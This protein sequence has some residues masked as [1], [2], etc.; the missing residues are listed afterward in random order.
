MKGLDLSGLRTGTAQVWGSVRLVPL[1]R[2][3][4]VPGLRLH[5]RL[6]DADLT[7]VGSGRAPHYLSYVPHAF[8]AIWGDQEGPRACHGT[9]LLQDQARPDGVRLRAL[10]RQVQRQ[11]QDRLRFLPLHLAMEG[12]LSLH[13]GGP[14]TAW[15]DWFHTTVRHGLSPRVES[16]YPGLAIP[17]LQAALRVFEIVHGQCGLA[18]HVA[19][20]LAAVTVTPHSADYRTLHTSLLLDMFGELL[21][22]NGLLNTTATELH[23]PFDPRTITSLQDLHTELARQ[24]RA[25]QDFHRHTMLTDL[26]TPRD[27]HFQRLYRLGDFTLWRFLPAFTPERNNHIGEVITDASGRVA[28]LKTLLL[29][30]AQTRRGHLL[31]TLAAADWH[32]E[33]A[34]AG[35]G[36]DRTGL[37]SRMERAGM[38]HLLHPGVLD[39]HRAAL[40]RGRR[41]I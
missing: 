20:T 41:T 15:Q 19:D 14:S 26:L 32:L 24:R 27:H 7:V 12:L 37:I 17:G 11:A 29:S 31:R 35:L 36:T 39:R 1:I 38:A 21:Y 16:T 2:D 8:V 40:R 6:N 23:A 22:V 25:W 4:P 34:A 30:N 33:T 5:P 9:Q 10:R 3:E 13:F 28:Y 18:I